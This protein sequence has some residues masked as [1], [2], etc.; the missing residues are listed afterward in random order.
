M[1]AN[2]KAVF[3]MLMGHLHWFEAHW[4]WFSPHLM[5]L[6]CWRDAQMPIVVIFVLTRTAITPDNDATGHFTPYTCIQG[7]SIGCLL[8]GYMYSLFLTSTYCIA[9]NFEWF[10]LSI[11]KYAYLFMHIKLISMIALIWKTWTHEMCHSAYPQKW[12]PYASVLLVAVVC[13]IQGTDKAWGMFVFRWCWIVA[14]RREY[15]I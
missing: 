10:D 15:T 4:N 5:D 2:K 9:G 6:L 14:P 7:N 3:V 1:V 11:T 13:K 8:C 12:N